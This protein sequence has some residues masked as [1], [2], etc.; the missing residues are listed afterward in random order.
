MKYRKGVLAVHKPNTF[1]SHLERKLDLGIK[2][3][4]VYTGEDCDI[5]FID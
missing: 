5:K 3:D 2:K 1:R 4:Y